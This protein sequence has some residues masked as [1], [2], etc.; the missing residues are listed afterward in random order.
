VRKVTLGELGKHAHAG[1]EAHAHG[2]VAEISLE[3]HVAAGVQHDLAPRRAN[4][5][6]CRGVE[7][8]P[9]TLGPRSPEERWGLLAFHNAA[10]E[11]RNL[12]RKR[13][14]V[15]NGRSGAKR[16]RR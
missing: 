1:R 6:R 8:K 4:Y 12:R 9:V 5:L 2:A 3:E 10:D 15:N 11:T 13:G 7:R 14:A 16:R